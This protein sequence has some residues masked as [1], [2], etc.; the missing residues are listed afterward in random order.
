M[1]INLDEQCFFYHVRVFLVENLFWGKSPPQVILFFG[2][3]G[4][5]VWVSSEGKSYLTVHKKIFDKKEI[6]SSRLPAFPQ[7]QIGVVI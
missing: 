4:V 6:I 7:L 3:R 1:E 5:I 2:A